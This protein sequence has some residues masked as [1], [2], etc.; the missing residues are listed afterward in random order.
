MLVVIDCFT[1]IIHYE[2]LKVIFDVLSLAKVIINIIV[3]HHNIPKSIII[4]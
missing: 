3:H 4:D 1:K 2:P